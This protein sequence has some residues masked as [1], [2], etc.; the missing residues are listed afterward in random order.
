MSIFNLICD[1]VFFLIDIVLSTVTLIVESIDFAQM[2]VLE[3]F[4]DWSSLPSQVLWVLDYM[5]FGQCLTMLA[6]AYGIRLLLNLIP[7]AFTRI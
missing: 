4:S 7:A 2:S 6:G 1:F 5:N 3:N